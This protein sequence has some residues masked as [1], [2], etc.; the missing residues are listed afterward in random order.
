[1]CRSGD[2]VL[3]S[4]IV[5]AGGG[6]SGVHSRSM[7]A[8]RRRCYV[9]VGDHVLCLQFPEFDLIWKT[10]A[11]VATVFGIYFLPD[12]AISGRGLDFFSAPA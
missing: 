9:A 11:D 1:M 6:T 5:I 7:I 12:F 3:G 4:A 2:K 8:R 10:K